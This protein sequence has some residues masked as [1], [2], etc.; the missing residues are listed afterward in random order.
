MRDK[1]EL[2]P[3]TA[4]RVEHNARIVQV[5][6]PGNPYWYVVEYPDG[7][8]ETVS[9]SRINQISDRARAV[10][11]ADGSM[12]VF[13]TRLSALGA[14]ELFHFLRTHLNEF[15]AIIQQS[16]GTCEYIPD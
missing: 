9:L 7:R 6:E 1:R 3:G 13:S 11:D 4:I 2:L 12:Q 5:A 8:Q 14:V 15:E 16:E 10:V